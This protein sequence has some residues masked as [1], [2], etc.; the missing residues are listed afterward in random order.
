MQTS[1]RPVQAVNTD[2][3]QRDFDFYVQ[4]DYKVSSKLTL[5]LG[6][7]W[8]IIPGMYEKNGYVTNPDLNLPNAA[9]GN[10]PGALRFADQEDRKTFIDTYYRRSSLVWAWPTPRRRQWRS[11]RATARATG[12]PRRTATTMISAASSRWATTAPST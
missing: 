6:V 2:Y 11:A 4:D 3:Y 12:Q 7:R 10:L 9:A 1:S 8:Q 5:N